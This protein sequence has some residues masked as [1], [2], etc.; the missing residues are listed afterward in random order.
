MTLS[1]P[2][3]TDTQDPVMGDTVNARPG[4]TGSLANPGAAEPALHIRGITAD[5]GTGPVLSDITLDVPRGAITVLVG[6]NGC[7]KSTLLKTVARQLKPSRGHVLLDGQ[8]TS[9]W[10]RTRF[11]HRVGFLPQ[12]PVAPEGVTVLDLISRGR[13]PH[14]GAFGRWRADDDAAVAEAVELTGLERLLGRQVTELSGGQR[15]R[16]WIAL[17]LAQQTDVLLLDEPTTYLDIA[18][19]VDVLDI[20]SDLQRQRG[21]T[22]VMVLHELSM[23]A[24]YAD[25]LVALKGGSVLASGTARD[26]MTDH[27]VSEVFGMAARVIH[28]RESDARL[29]IPARTR[30]AA[31]SDTLERVPWA[32]QEGR[33]D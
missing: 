29:V 30:G 28:D 6:A 14:R 21:I 16:V 22:L 10:S 13:H 11:A 17:A 7:G 19:Q 12:D 32:P 24:R 3:S 5:Y 31:S 23:A 1:N 27:T 25:R 33:N 20:L 9:E 18:H 26:V 2:P 4:V 15:Q 8:D